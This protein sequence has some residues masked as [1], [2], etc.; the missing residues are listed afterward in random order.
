MKT[1][2]LRVLTVTITTGLLFAVVPEPAE[3]KACGGKNQS[4][5]WSLNPAKW[6]KGNL[7]YQGNGKPGQGRCVSRSAP[8]KSCGGLN[9]SSCWSA[10]PKDWCRGDLMYKPTGI[11]GQGTCIQR[12]AKDDCGGPGEKSCWNI[13]PARWCEGDLKYKPTGIPGQGRCIRRVSDD[14]LREVAGAVA[15]QIGKLGTNNPLNDLR[16]CL[17][18]PERL[19]EL[20]RALASRSANGVNALLRQCGVSPQALADYGN[21]V[22]GSFDTAAASRSAAGVA[23]R[24][25]STRSSS[26]ADDRTWSLA[27][28]AGVSGVAKVGVEGGVGYRIELKSAPEARFFLSGGVA[29]GIGLAGGADVSVGLSYSSMPTE[30]WAREVGKSVSFSGKAL[31]GGGVAIDFDSGALVP[32]G[33][34]L[35]GGVGAGAEAAL[36]TATGSLY[37]YNF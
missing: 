16:N 32:N 25:V 34:T 28:G 5:C 35:S 33:F 9:Q 6:C 29:A 11:P 36:V 24:S 26:S 27:I 19:A 14:D 3:A 10:N 13:N 23:A 4:S 7:Q 15:A 12:P 31:Y 22:L 17:K 30:H 1:Q 21:R 20:Q 8:K 18:R 2:I 37:L